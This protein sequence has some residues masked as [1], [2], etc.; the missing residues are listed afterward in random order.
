[1]NADSK[2]LLTD[3]NTKRGRQKHQLLRSE[4]VINGKA[5][6]SIT[7]NCV[8]TIEMCLIFFGKE[9]AQ[10]LMQILDEKFDRFLL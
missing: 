6:R 3:V 9:L 2:D 8:Q 4:K 10:N 5:Q 1:M 7:E